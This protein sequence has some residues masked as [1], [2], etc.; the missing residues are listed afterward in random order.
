D[1]LFGWRSLGV[2]QLLR[3]GERKLAA[4]KDEQPNLEAEELLQQLHGVVTA[5]G[6]T[7]ESPSQYRNPW[8][9]VLPQEK[10]PSQEEQLAKPQY[11]FSND[12]KLAFLLVS[13]KKDAASETFTYAQKSIRE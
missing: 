6:A 7:I 10:G 3:E 4:W 5:A 11:F 1:P 2:Q 8:H 13:P 9:S 12:G